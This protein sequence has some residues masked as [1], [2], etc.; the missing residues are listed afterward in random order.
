[1]D[2]WEYQYS[3]FA[4]AVLWAAR[5]E[6]D[7]TLRKLVASADSGL[8]A[9]FS[10][11]RPREVVIESRSRGPN[12]AALARVERRLSVQRGESR[13]A[14]PSAE[15]APSGWPGGRS[16]VDVV[17]RDPAGATLAWGWAGVEA[18]KAATLSALNANAQVYRQGETMSVVARASGSLEGLTL[19]V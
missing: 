18:P 4:R 9:A 14:I 15:L 13:L 2:Y 11:D 6:G 7:L 16:V 3:L 17:V 10:S 8:S 1:W 19:R 12:G 5:G